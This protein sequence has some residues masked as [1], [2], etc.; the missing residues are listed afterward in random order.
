LKGPKTLPGQ[1]VAVLL[2]PRCQREGGVS[3]AQW[4]LGL[5]S[6]AS[7]TRSADL[8]EVRAEVRRLDEKFEFVQSLLLAMMAKLEISVEKKVGTPSRGGP[9]CSIDAA[10][11]NSRGP[12]SPL[13]RSALK[14][15]TSKAVQSTCVGDLPIM[16]SPETPSGS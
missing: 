8:E 10:K 1:E 4:G 5:S 2:L 3:D 6:N 11:S 13:T 7:R 15:P 12:V 14:E 16:A 9:T